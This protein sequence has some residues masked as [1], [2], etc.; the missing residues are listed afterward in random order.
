MTAKFT[1][2]PWPS[3]T[4]PDAPP[5]EGQATSPVE[6]APIAE[7]VPSGPDTASSSG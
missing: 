4:P 7:P 6:P 1:N 2:L 3:P 5:A